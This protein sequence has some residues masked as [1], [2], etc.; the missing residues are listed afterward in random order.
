MSSV[1][2]TQALEVAKEV[3]KIE[4]AAIQSL[5]KRIDVS[6]EPLFLCFEHFNLVC[7]SMGKFTLKFKKSAA[8]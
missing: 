5:A 6:F 2:M 1:A 7:T 8:L 4:S 3:L